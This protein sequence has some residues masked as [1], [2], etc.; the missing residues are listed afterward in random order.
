MSAQRSK[1]EQAY[2]Y[3]LYVAPHWSERFAELADEHL[4]LPKKGRVLYV[5]SGTGGHALALAERHA[6]ELSFVCLDESA[7]RTELAQAKAVAL[8]L[9]ARVEFRLSQLETLNFEDEA[10]DFVIGDASLVAP[11]RLPEIAAEMARVARSKATIALILTTASSFGEFFSIYWEA[12]TNTGLEAHA[13]KV[14][15][16]INELPTTSDVETLLARAGLVKIQSWT[17]RE[18]F[19]FE[20]GESFTTAPLL[21]DFLFTSW[22]EFLSEVEQAQV[23]GEVERLINEERQGGEWALSIK[24]TLASGRKAKQILLTSK[25]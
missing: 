24:A 15:S 18:D 22:F 16:L 20:T 5:G 17:Q 3:D 10:F 7:E 23:T 13:A 19:E 2:L 1:K 25:S 8:K 9:D 21:T 14:E 6:P 11:E 12:L 4:Q